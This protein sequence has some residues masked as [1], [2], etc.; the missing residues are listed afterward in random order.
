MSVRPEVLG[1]IL[2]CAAVTLVPRIL[3]LLLARRFSLP[4]WFETWL[5]YVPVAVI[6]AL[7]VDQV[8]L[9]GPA[10]GFLL[11]PQ[12]LVAGVVALGV[13]VFTRSLGYSVIAG[14]VV[15]ALAGQL[16]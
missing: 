3:P 12:R 1:L 4:P 5:G 8:L 15:F 14:V 11:D 9:T 10:D 13:A 16:W 6:G 2:A 7:L